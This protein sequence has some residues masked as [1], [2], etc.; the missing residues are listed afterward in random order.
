MKYIEIGLG[1]TWI[2]RTET[3]LPDGSEREQK[4]IIRPIIFHS[5]YLRIWLGNTVMIW[6]SKEGFKR[7]R[8]SRNAFKLILGMTSFVSESEKDR[9]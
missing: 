6:D 9:N 2:V 3:E 1:N 8:K 7:T 4:G 5:I